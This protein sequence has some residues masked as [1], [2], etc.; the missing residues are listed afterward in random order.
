MF[1]FLWETMMYLSP[2]HTELEH[3]L[4]NF[5]GRIQRGHGKKKRGMRVLAPPMGT[6]GRGGLTN[7]NLLSTLILTFPLNPMPR[8]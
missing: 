7:T 1:F 3:L 6:N 2:K 8:L 5:G 4:G